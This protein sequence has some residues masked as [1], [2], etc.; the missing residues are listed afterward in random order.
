MKYSLSFCEITEISKDIYETISKEG[1]ILDKSCA[2]EAYNF[3]DKI[4]D[5]PFGLL[6]NHK[7]S[8]SHSFEG[9]RDI[10]N[11]PLQRKTALLVYNNT[12]KSNFETA[13]QVKNA[14]A[15]HSLSPHKIFI[16]RN[17][18]IEWLKELD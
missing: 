15:Q 3:W 12:Q 5:K 9:G 4:R 7:I 8:F 14:T 18:A 1:V 17:Q 2:E 11:H 16:D 10:G 13:L 6:V